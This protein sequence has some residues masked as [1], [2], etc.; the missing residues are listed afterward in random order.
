LRWI[1]CR[2]ATVPSVAVPKV[3]ISDCPIHP[4]LNVFLLCVYMYRMCK[5]I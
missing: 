2:R 3:I 1:I 5:T 4:L